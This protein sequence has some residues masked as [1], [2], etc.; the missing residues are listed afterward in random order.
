MPNLA[1]IGEGR[2]GYRTQTKFSQ[3]HVFYITG[4]TLCTYQTK[5]CCGTMFNLLP[6]LALIGKGVQ[7]PKNQKFDR[8]RIL[9]VSAPTR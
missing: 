4:V 5:I 3:D 9:A 7:E 2:G 8:N 6:N 1:L